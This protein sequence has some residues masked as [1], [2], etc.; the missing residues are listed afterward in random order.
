V[1]DAIDRVPLPRDTED[2]LRLLAGWAGLVWCALYG[3]FCVVRGGDVP[4]LWLLQLA[5]HEVGHLAFSPFG[6]RTML[7]M[8]SGTEILAP[9]ALAAGLV[10]WRARRNLI[11]AG[12]CLAITAGAFIH[13]AA[14]I[15]DAPRGEA[16]LVGSDESDW[17]R[18]LDEHW[19]VLYK[20]D[21][22][23]GWARTAGL[24]VWL[25]AV[26]SVIGGMSV[27]ARRLRPEGPTATADPVR[28]V[29]PVDPDEMWRAELTP[30]GPS[31]DA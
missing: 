6:E 20:A 14:Y 29:P 10:L 27:V 24:L 16:V 11:A 1:I 7:L 18:L 2:R 12:M 25:A 3:W 15:A 9:L 19:D 31:S 23:A 28:P 5:T 8:G 26:A 4:V 21:V 17:L 30:R 13:T 22:Y